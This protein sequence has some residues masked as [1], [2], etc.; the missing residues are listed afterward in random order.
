MSTVL[1]HEITYDGDYVVVHGGDNWTLWNKIVMDA[2][3]VPTR[4]R[5]IKRRKTQKKNPWDHF[6]KR[7][8]H[9]RRRQITK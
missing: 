4:P 6:V 5:G 3:D 8:R 2:Y 9:K 7:R 1:E